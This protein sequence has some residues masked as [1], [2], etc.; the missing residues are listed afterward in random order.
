VD[1]AAQVRIA[2]RRRGVFVPVCALA[3]AALF[4]VGLAIYRPYGQGFTFALAIMGTGLL[5]ALVVPAL[6]VLLVIGPHW[7]QRLQHLQLMRWERE[8]R[9]W[10]AQERERYLAALPAS[11]RDALRHVLDA[12]RKIALRRVDGACSPE[13]KARARS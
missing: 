5:V 7:R 6:A 11:Q 9:L 12:S 13:G 10:R 8:R 2:E 1:I 3:G 4:S